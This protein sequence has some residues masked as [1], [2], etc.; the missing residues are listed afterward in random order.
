M[1]LNG[2]TLYMLPLGERHRLKHTIY[3]G[4][5]IVLDN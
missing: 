3:G 5:T 4:K 2:Q 1:Y